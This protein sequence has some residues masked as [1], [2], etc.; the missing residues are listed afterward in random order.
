MR[1]LPKMIFI[2]P[3]S[4]NLHVFSQFSFPRLGIFILG[5]IVK[6]KGWDVEIIIEQSQKID[7]EKIRPVDMV[8]IS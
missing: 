6:E 3:K 7:F 4:P 1:V 2:E 8:G 5:A